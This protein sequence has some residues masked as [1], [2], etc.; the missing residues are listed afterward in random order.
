MMNTTIATKIISMAQFD[1]ID[2]IK[3]P[4]CIINNIVQQYF[5][6]TGDKSNE[7]RIKLSDL[8]ANSF[9]ERKELAINSIDMKENLRNGDSFSIFLNET[10]VTGKVYLAPKSISVEITSP[11]FGRMAG[12]DLDLIAP[13]IWTESPEMESVANEEG[14][15]KAAILLADIYFSLLI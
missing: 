8:V 13:V 10:I 7:T 14:R 4:D 9:E 2:Y 3:N 11:Y 6:L 5:E 1:A 15:K 12:A